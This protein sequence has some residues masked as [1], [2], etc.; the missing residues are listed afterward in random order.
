MMEYG[1]EI[2]NWGMA[3]EG[4]FSFVFNFILEQFGTEHMFLTLYILNLI[5]SIISFK[6]GFARKLTLIKTII[7]YI[8]LALGVYLLTIFS[9]FQLPITESLI[10]ISLVLAIYR[11]RLYQERKNR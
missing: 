9:I 4:S 7:V 1:D 11:F 10:L 6:L 8:M 3:M 5:F 2:D